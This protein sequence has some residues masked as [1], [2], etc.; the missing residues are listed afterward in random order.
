MSFDHLNNKDK[1]DHDLNNFNNKLINILN[2]LTLNNNTCNCN[3]YR[4]CPLRNIHIVNRKSNKQIQNRI[5]F[6]KNHTLNDIKTK[7]IKTSTN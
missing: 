3:K 2:T 5:E 7:I 1:I 6:L 4:L